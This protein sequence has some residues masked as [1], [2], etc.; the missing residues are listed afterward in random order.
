MAEQPG[1][2]EPVPVGVI[3]VA[4]ATVG[5][6][7]PAPANLARQI[8]SVRSDIRRLKAEVEALALRKADRAVTEAA[9]KAMRPAWY[10]PAVAMAC[11]AATVVMLRDR[12][13]DLRP[14]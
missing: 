2:G 3:D 8:R 14:F 5:V 6:V 4:H 1:L 9:G 7:E 12:L 13:P 11:V 10:L